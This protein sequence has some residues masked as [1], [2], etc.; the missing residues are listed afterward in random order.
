MNHWIEIDCELLCL[1]TGARVVRDR[2]LEREAVLHH[3]PG[4]DDQVLFKGDVDRA[5]H[6]YAVLRAKLTGG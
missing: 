1:E 3:V 6:F 5:D 4:D 2:R